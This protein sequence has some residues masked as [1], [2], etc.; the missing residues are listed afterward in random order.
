[1]L[2]GCFSRGWARCLEE[3]TGCWAGEVL[4]RLVSYTIYAFDMSLVCS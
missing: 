4:K 3:V 2:C 1:M